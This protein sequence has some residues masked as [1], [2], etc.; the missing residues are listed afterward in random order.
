MRFKISRFGAFSGL[1]V[2]A[3]ALRL[4]YL[5][6]VR[7]GL[8]GNADSAAY[9]ALAVSHRMGARIRLKKAAPVPAVSR[10]TCNVHLVTQPSWRWSMHLG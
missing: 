6:V 9:K 5:A 3:L 8:L 1:V 10:L 7:T 2:L 4:G